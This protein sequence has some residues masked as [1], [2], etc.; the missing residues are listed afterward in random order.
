MCY[1]RPEAGAEGL[2]WSA[3]LLCWGVA[4][5]DLVDHQFARDLDS[6]LLSQENEMENRI[7]QRIPD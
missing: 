5:D 3:K 2:L 1:A 7:C 6:D 4:L